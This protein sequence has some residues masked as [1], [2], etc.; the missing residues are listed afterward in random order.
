MTLVGKPRGLRNRE[1]LPSWVAEHPVGWGLASAVLS[2]ALVA[3]VSAPV[4]AVV[5]AGTCVGFGNWFIWRANGPA[6]EWKRRLDTRR[7]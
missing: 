5:A 6:H 2:G 7:K 1:P 3:A 4:G